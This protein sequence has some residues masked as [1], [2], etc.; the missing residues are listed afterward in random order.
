MKNSKNKNIN[1]NNINNDSQ[2]N[3]GLAAGNL[4]TATLLAV[5]EKV[6]NPNQN[7]SFVKINSP[8][9]E[10]NV[11]IKELKLIF[12]NIVQS[13]ATNYPY[14]DPNVTANVKLIISVELLDKNDLT[15]ENTLN[16]PNIQNNQMMKIS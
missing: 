16:T 8:F 3:Y 4:A 12:E 11:D 6:I 9:D 13:S 15:E 7:I 5:L 1:I 10:F 14:N 2:I